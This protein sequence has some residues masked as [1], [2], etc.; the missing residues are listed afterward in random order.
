MSSGAHSGKLRV[1]GTLQARG[2]VNGGDGGIVETSGTYVNVHDVDLGQ[3]TILVGARAAG[4]V[5]G[6]WS[7]YS[8]KLTIGANTP[9]YN[10]GTNQ[11]DTYISDTD[12]NA[13]LNS[14][15]SVSMATHYKGDSAVFSDRLFIEGD[16]AIAQSQ[17]QPRQHPDPG[18]GHR[19]DG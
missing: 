16:A 18:F 5:G 19:C 2:G 15:A 6:L 11:A 10:N 9:S 3:A 1:Y 14:G 4:A 12:I 13:V 7:V 8:P 17:G